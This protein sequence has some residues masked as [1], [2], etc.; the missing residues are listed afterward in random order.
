MYDDHKAVNTAY[1]KKVMECFKNEFK[2]DI[3]KR[4]EELAKSLKQ[5]SLEI[6]TFEKKHILEQ[7]KLE[8][9][10]LGRI[11]ELIPDVS[12][13][14]DELANLQKKQ[15][16]FN[17]ELTKMNLVN[18]FITVPE[19]VQLYKDH[20]Q[21]LKDKLNQLTNKCSAKVPIIKIYEEFASDESDEEIISS[22]RA[23]LEG[24]VKG[25][26]LQ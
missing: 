4:H 15:T 21:K 11:I 23:S 14:H 5:I 19:K 8:S 24:Q 9:M 18:K 20:Q 2:A 1:K 3:V 7:G 25:T 26:N 16:N 10:E 6:E 17:D 12:K 13:I 22:T